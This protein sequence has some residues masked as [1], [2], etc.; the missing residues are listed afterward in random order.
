MK[1]IVDTSVW[2][3]AL[4]RRGDSGAPAA[5]VLRQ[6]ISESR[7]V[8]LGCIRQEI[9]SGVRS[10]QQFEV[11][12][13]KLRAF[14]DAILQTADYEKAAEF[15]NTCR[16]KGIQGSNT[17]FL[18]CATAANRGYSVFTTDNDFANFRRVIPFSLF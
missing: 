7:I 14:P 16:R 12:R 18:I 11:L 8:M 13:N 2:S 6:L 4:R 1:I 10:N 9:L 17:D 3:Q 5:D 15:F